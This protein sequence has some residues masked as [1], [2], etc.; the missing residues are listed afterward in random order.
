MPR[1]ILLLA[2][3]TFGSFASMTHAADPPSE[4]TVYF[5]TYTR[6]SDSKGIY[7]SNLNLKTGALSQPELKAEIANPSF[8]AIAPDGR[9][10]YCVAELAEVEGKKN[11]GGVA[12]F[13]ID[14]ATKGLKPL[15][16]QSSG[17]AGPCHIVVD[18]S[19]RNALIA[20]YGGG[21]VACLPIN[22]DGSLKPASAFIQHEGKVADQKRQQ[23]PH[24]HS[25]NVDHNN[26]FAV[27]ADLG[28]DKLF[29][30]RFD[31]EKGTLTPNDPPST[32]LQPVDG[33]RHFAFH[34]GGDFAYAINEIS[35]SITALRY[36]PQHGVL[37]AMQTVSTVPDDQK[38]PKNST[39][40]VQ[41][42]PSGKW[43]YGS[44]RG[45]DSIAMFSVDPKSGQL[46][47]LGQEPCGGKTPRNF[48]IDP[49]GQFMLV[50][51]QDSNNV[52]VFRIN[53]ETG[54][55]EK[56]DHEIACPKPVCVKF[57]F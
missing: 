49:T 54:K 7:A 22:Q 53:Q 35:Q 41:V 31:A 6:G 38:G 19:G 20:N 37:Y 25:I 33:P 27:A 28:L 40:E 57:L 14:P 32:S 52:V 13:E 44:N 23:G 9:H 1:R 51:N 48:G 24:G 17:G 43:V 10:L 45:P 42:H 46:T 12:A 50:A 26:A 56:T 8:L 18:H 29:V 30:Y 11:A 5:G 21:S 15:N 47:S 36:A 2:A 55:L 39:A 34:P 4:V 16:Q 3:L